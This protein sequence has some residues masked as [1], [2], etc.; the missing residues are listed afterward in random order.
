MYE[1]SKA[2]LILF[3]PPDQ[4]T[5]AVRMGNHLCQEG[6]QMMLAARNPHRIFILIK[7]YAAEAAATIIF[8]VWLLKHVLHELRF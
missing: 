4:S 1:V 7:V 5:F 6:Q 2:H 8:V 3:W